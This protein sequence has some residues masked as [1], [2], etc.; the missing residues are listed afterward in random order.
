MLLKIKLLQTLL[1]C[2]VLLCSCQDEYY[3]K[4]IVGNKIRI[5]FN[6]VDQV[7]NDENIL[8]D[9]LKIE[10]SV[11]EVDWKSITISKK[12]DQNSNAEF[13]AFAPSSELH[14]FEEKTGRRL[15]EKNSSFFICNKMGKILLDFRKNKGP[16]YRI[17]NGQA[18]LLSGV[19]E[20]EKT[21][22]EPIEIKTNKDY[23]LRFSV[24]N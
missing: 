6:N 10:H 13:L 8:I 24:I 9:D 22:G 7:G 4:N 20:F 12:K 21:N 1:I 3:S 23:P 2:S 16:V 18:Y 19:I 11:H 17:T 14:L 15:V 5:D